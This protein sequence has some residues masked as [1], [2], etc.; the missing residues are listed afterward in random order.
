MRGR[1]CRLQ[2]LLALAS[3]VILG[4]ESRGTHGHILLSQI[5]DSTWR[6]RPPYLYPPGTGWPSYT[7]RHWVPFSSPPTTRRA[8][9]EVFEPLPH[10]LWLTQSRSQSYVTTDS[11]SASLSWCQAPIWDLRPDFFCLTVASL[12]MWG[13]FSD[14]RTGLFL[15][16]TIY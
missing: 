13:A 7:A 15:Q 5:R 12:L 16:C 6:A 9:V 11:Q 2:L 1:V 3:S 8:T 10:G 14:E 4:S